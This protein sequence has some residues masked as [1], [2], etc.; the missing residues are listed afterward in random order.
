MIEALIERI[1][2]THDPR[3]TNV[4]HPYVGLVLAVLWATACGFSG[5]EAIAEFARARHARIARWTQTAARSPGPR[6]FKRLLE[7]LDPAVPAL[8]L[9]AAAVDWDLIALD[10]KTIRGAQTSGD[11]AHVVEAYSLRR[12]VC[13]GLVDAGSRGGEKAAFEALIRKHGGDAITFTIDANGAS[14]QIAKA[15]VDTG[16]DY[17]I[18][19]KEN[20]PRTL[21][22]VTDSFGRLD[23]G[24]PFVEVSKG[25]GRLEIRRAWVLPV[26][27]LFEFEPWPGLMAA[28]MVERTREIKGK[29][30]VER[31]YH[32][33][34]RPLSPEAY[35]AAAR[36]HW[37]I[38]NGVHNVVDRSMG[39]DLCQVEGPAARALAAL[40]RSALSRL[41][42][43]PGFRSVAA[44]MR[45]L[46][47]DP[48]S[49]SL[50]L[51]E[52]PAA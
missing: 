25:H 34:S 46:A 15:V 6:T 35:A 45:H 47:L 11:D 50:L 3:A 12:R 23:P 33:L 29:R 49:F 51:G 8:L 2:G 52:T 37:D 5:P 17:V 26:E 24:E 40:R 28:G 43:I 19:L 21:A 13:L 27:A 10:G 39:E 38:E 16:S 20:A 1:A 32:L 22:E 18:G 9:D 30:S 7:R 31:A 41:R 44:A 14:R 48:E 42:R 4:T 36:G